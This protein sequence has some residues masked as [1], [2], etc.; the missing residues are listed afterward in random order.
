MDYIQLPFRFILKTSFT[1]E[2]VSFSLT[3]QKYFTFF[4]KDE[5][6]DYP[7]PKPSLY[8]SNSKSLIK[9]W[10][11]LC[12][13]DSNFRVQMKEK[14][15]SRIDHTYKVLI[16]TKEFL[17]PT[18]FCIQNLNDYKFYHKEKID[19]W[20]ELW[21][22]VNIE[23][24]SLETIILFKVLLENYCLNSDA[25]NEDNINRN[26]LWKEDSIEMRNEKSYWS[27]NAYEEGGGGD[28]WSDPTDFF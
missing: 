2:N 11:I 10:Q 28:E 23:L 17:T 20:I 7:F 5:L 9:E 1:L 21:Q 15:I 18:D 6:T 14:L 19:I 24:E 12:I 3:P 25:I 13:S 4:S 22:N 8:E 26:K 27:K 16:D